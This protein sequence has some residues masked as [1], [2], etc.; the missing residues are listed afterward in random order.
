[1]KMP[2][3]RYVLDARPVML[4]TAPIVYAMPVALVALDQF[5][6]VCRAT[7]FRVYAIEKV[8]RRDYLIYDRSRLAYLNA[9][10]TLNRAYCSYANGLI[11]YPREIAARPE[12]YWCPIKYAR[13]VVAAHR[14]DAPFVEYDD[15]EACQ[16]Q[17]PAL[18]REPRA[19]AS[20]PK[21]QSQQCD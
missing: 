9:I 5:L 7:C 16:D 1:M 21:A 11:G 15:A 13:H 6:T 18:R 17:L 2:Q 20:D 19:D 12:Q 8:R 10:E 3:L 4:L 14:H